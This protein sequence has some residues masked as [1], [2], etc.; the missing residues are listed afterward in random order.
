[1]YLWV[2]T[3]ASTIL[4]HRND[5]DVGASELRRRRA[6]CAR[7]HSTS[8]HWAHFDGFIDWWAVNMNT[9]E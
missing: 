4:W 8:A 7:S 6:E 2:V 3:E 1:V 9:L 5:D